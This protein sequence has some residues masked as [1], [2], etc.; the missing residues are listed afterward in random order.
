MVDTNEIR[1]GNYLMLKDDLVKVVDI[2]R[3]SLRIYNQS[4]SF[5]NIKFTK[6]NDVNPIELTI[7]VLQ[8][9]GFTIDKPFGDAAGNVNCYK[10]DFV[11]MRNFT[12]KWRWVW[13]YKNDSVI[14]NREFF[15][16]NTIDYLHE[17][18]NLWY[19]FYKQELIYNK[20]K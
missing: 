4:K 5:R 20:K 19:A 7:D 14:S 2:R 17:L 15:I 6:S 10:E 11:M 18:Q 9:C 13:G 8:N 12:A 3:K 16:W 1:L